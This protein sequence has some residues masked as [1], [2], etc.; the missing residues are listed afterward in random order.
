MEV[1]FGGTSTDTAVATYPDT[2]FTGWMHAKMTFTAI[3]TSET[4]A[5]PGYGGP[6][7]LPPAALLL[8]VTMTSV[9]EPSALLLLA[10]G[11]IGCG[12]VRRL[13]Q[14]ARVLNRT[15]TPPRLSHSAGHSVF[16][17]SGPVPS[18]RAAGEATWSPLRFPAH[19]A[20]PGPSSPVV[21]ASGCTIGPALQ[22]SAGS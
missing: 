22:G 5:F 6:N 18:S 10:V 8:D 12:V 3:A 17:P 15:P 13:R 11:V 14:P 21:S 1:T 19:R 7:G 20:V 9:P 16:S 4:L 2:G